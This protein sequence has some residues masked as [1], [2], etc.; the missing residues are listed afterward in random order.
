MVYSFR[1]QRSSKKEYFY[2]SSRKKNK[3]ILHYTVHV[4]DKDRHG[5]LWVRF[6]LG[7]CCQGLSETNGQMNDTVIIM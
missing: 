6:S 5:R 3:E 7:E 1:V 2:Y 4:Q